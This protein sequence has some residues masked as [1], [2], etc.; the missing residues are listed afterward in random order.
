VSLV[1]LLAVQ[2]AGAGYGVPR[3]SISRA[4]VTCQMYHFSLKPCPAPCSTQ[5]AGSK[6]AR[7][8]VEADLTCSVVLDKPDGDQGAWAGLAREVLRADE[9]LPQRARSAEL[10]H[11]ATTHQI[12]A[13]ASGA[14]A[15][16]PPPPLA[17]GGRLRFAK[18][19]RR[20]CS[21][22]DHRLALAG[23]RVELHRAFGAI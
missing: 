12:D 4:G 1:H 8:A 20:H 16:C 9:A 3:R 7:E 10:G 6:R 21:H 5:P 23:V 2:R 11:E 14:P 19:C 17:E 15:G 13:A 18:V 22:R